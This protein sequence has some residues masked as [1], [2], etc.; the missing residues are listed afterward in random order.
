M[1]ESLQTEL[2]GHTQQVGIRLVLVQRIGLSSLK[3]QFH[4]QLVRKGEFL[5]VVVVGFKNSRSQER[6]MIFASLVPVVGNQILHKL[7]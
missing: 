4:F 1:F 2:I 3:T 6:I 7:Q 5:F